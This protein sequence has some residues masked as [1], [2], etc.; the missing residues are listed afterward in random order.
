VTWADDICLNDVDYKTV[1]PVLDILIFFD[2]KTMIFD[3]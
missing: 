2:S 3:P 1:S